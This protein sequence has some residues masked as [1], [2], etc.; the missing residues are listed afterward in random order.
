MDF[1]LLKLR[2]QK[3]NFKFTFGGEYPII[4]SLNLFV[5]FFLEW[6]LYCDACDISVRNIYCEDIFSW[7]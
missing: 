5:S 2:T 3:F 6:K 1:H 4:H 7:A